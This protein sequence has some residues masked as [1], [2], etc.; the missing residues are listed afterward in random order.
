M[1]LCGLSG[2]LS[3]EV[4]CVSCTVSCL[5]VA[6]YLS[7]QTQTLFRTGE[8]AGELFSVVIKGRNP[9]DQVSY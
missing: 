6:G 1:V 4:F 9:S 5:T 3:S 7:G 8:T 2:D